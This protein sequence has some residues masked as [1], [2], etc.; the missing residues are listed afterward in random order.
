MDTGRRLRTQ[1]TVFRY[2]IPH[3]RLHFLLLS[4]FRSHHTVDRNRC[5]RIYV[6]IHGCVR[7]PSIP[8]P[9]PGPLYMFS[10]LRL[11]FPPSFHVL[12]F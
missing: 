3:N 6:V 10:I 5:I 7:L 1:I 2:P 4:A 11:L 12:P 9:L 8:T